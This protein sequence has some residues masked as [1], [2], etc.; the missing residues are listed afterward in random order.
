MSRSMIYEMYFNAFSNSE[1]GVGSAVA[2]LFIIQCLFVTFVINKLL[3]KEAI[4][5]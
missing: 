1:F 5:F 2:V 3:K 4:Q